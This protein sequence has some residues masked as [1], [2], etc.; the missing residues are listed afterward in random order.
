MTGSAGQELP[1]AGVR[2]LAL[3]HAVAAPIAT[4]HLADMGAEVIKVE[5]PAI[6]DFARRYDQSVHGLSSFFVWLN[7]GKRSL[8]LDVK[9][10]GAAGLLARLVARSDVVVQNLAPGASD[11]LGLSYAALSP[12]HPRLVLCDI[13]GY[14]RD[15]PYASRKAYDLLIQAEAGLM[16]VTGTPEAP[17]RAG[18]SAADIA[19]GM[20][21]YS[22]I[23]A[24]LVR[25]GNTG[26]GAHLQVTMLNAVAEWMG[27]A[28]Y[29]AAYGSGPPARLASGHPN[30]QPYGTYRT[31]DGAV[32]L[33][34]QNDGEWA[35]FCRDVLGRPE[36]ATD[37]RFATN[38]ARVA[39]GMELTAAIEAVFAGLDSA[40]VI[41]RLD[42]AGIANGRLNDAGQVWAHPQLAARDR[43]R[44]VGTP[45]GTVR[46]LLP[47]TEFADVE[48]AMGDVPA[49]GAHTT[50]I[51]SEIG[52]T[53]AE[54][55]NLRSTGTV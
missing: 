17:A 11:R 28:L 30:I 50:A 2:V 12:A 40:A 15:G 18:I 13:S 4:R 19:T 54:I 7:R 31:G 39:N 21:A 5:R 45:G 33:G 46:A 36:L 51:L 1:L 37:P 24:A 10:P 25:R 35:T 14:G 29:Q 34:I 23:L 27:H 8:T 9:K 44:E 3:E 48:L 53:E 47:P 20:Y 26:R 49:L 52:C 6:G 43:W 16:S 38:V 32:I 42:A 41:G 55:A 22:G